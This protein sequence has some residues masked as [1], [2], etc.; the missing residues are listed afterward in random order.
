MMALIGTQNSQYKLEFLLL[1][2]YLKGPRYSLSV[3]GLAHMICHPK[4]QKSLMLLQC[5]HQEA[6]GFP[7]SSCPLALL[8]QFW[9]DIVDR[10]S[11]EEEGKG[12]GSRRAISTKYRRVSP[13]TLF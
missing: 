8:Q 6:G 4:T 9:E 1:L 2:K 7:F 3:H 5:N 12:K 11:R 10:Y 13:G